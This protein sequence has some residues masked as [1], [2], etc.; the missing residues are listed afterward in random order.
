MHQIDLLPTDKHNGIERW[1]WNL[2]YRVNPYEVAY[3]LSKL[4]AK[5]SALV[6]LRYK[7]KIQWR[8]NFF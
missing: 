3:V 5:I 6:D 2:G 7:M 1:T 8:P 4:Q